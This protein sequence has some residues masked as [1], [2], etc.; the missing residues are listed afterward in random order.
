MLPTNTPSSIENSNKSFSHKVLSLFIDIKEEEAKMLFFSWCYFFTLMIGYYI[1]R[2]IRDEL[3]AA[4]GANSLPWLFT[5]TLSIT[6]LLNPIFA[7][8]VA[9]FS[10]RYFITISYRFF[11]ANILIF[12]AVFHLVPNNIWV[13]RIFFV[14]ISVFNL[15]IVSLFWAFTVDAFHSDQGKRLFGFIG[16]GGSVGAVVGSLL[17][18]SLVETFGSQLLLVLSCLLLELAVQ[19]VKRFPKMEGESSKNKAIFTE[20]PI[21]G[22]ISAGIANIAQ[23]PYLTA[24]CIYMLLFTIG[25]TF[26][27]FQQTFIV[28]QSIADKGA[29]TAYLAKIDL[30]I[31]V[32]TILIQVVFTGKI[33]KKLGITITLGVLPSLSIIGFA[34]LGIMPTLTTFSCFHIL[35]RAGHFAIARPMCEVLFTV[36]KPEDK[37]KAKNFIDTGVYR[38]GDQV[39]IWFSALLSWIGLSAT[40]VAFTSVPIALIWLTLAIWLGKQ[41]VA[42]TEN[43]D[44]NLH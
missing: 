15:F 43:N 40:N 5:A 21:G 11:L 2:P 25:S 23:S 41:Q 24:I 34:S 6:I 26:L 4:S 18:A 36:V 33:V 19:C 22:N 16:S 31:N 32:L 28:S 29:R 9:K 42:L 39:G 35:R 3:G 27:Y 10:V 30:I 13:G 14:W 44:L 7:W 8:L 12:F 20:S 38:F 37:Y 17:T 1:L